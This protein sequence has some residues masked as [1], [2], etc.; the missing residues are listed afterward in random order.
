MAMK[1]IYFII[2]FSSQPMRNHFGSIS[3]GRSM[4]VSHN[5]CKVRKRRE[6]KQS[7]LSLILIGSFMVTWCPYASCVLVLTANG[8]V[9]PS[10]LTF[11]SFFAKMSVFANPIIHSIF[12][13]D[14]RLRCRRLFVCVWQMMLRKRDKYSDVVSMLAVSPLNMVTGASF[15]MV[16]GASLKHRNGSLDVPEDDVSC[17]LCESKQI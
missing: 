7:V 8:H 1:C 16:T 9:D 3:R 15:N 4:R 5:I 10:L 2:N 11:A 12:M 17:S 13:K 14:F 6:R